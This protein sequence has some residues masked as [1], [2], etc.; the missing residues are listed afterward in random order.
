MKKILDSNARIQALFI[1][2]FGFMF[3]TIDDDASDCRFTAKIFQELLG[4]LNMTHFC[5]CALPPYVALVNCICWQVLDWSKCLNLCAEQR[6]FA[7]L[8]ILQHP[9]SQ[10]LL[11]VANGHVPA[12][13]HRV[14]KNLQPRRHTLRA[15][16]D[17]LAP[18]TRWILGGDYNLN[19]SMAKTTSSAS[20]GY[21]LDKQ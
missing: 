13:K 20:T 8:L 15:T 19:E 12:G 11:A 4:E 18:Y 2:E 16:S 7:M 9:A 1:C 3:P 10:E 5:V 14:G 17:L 21:Q 6:N